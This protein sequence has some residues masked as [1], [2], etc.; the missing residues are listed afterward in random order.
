MADR[1]H[2]KNADD[3]G[4]DVNM[5]NIFVEILNV[6]LF[7]DIEEQ[8]DNNRDKVQEK[9]LDSTSDPLNIDVHAKKSTIE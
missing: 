3:D 6:F 9:I 5:D 2:E 8:E 1:V 4:E 7:D